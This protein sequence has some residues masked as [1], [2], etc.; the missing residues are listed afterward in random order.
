MPKTKYGNYYKYILFFILGLLICVPLFVR[1]DVL[2]IR[3]WDESRLAM[4]SIEMLHN[5]NYLVT[6]YDG[7]PDMWNTK[8]P[9]L[10]WIQVAFMKSMG[11]NELAVRIPSA[12]AGLL[13]CFML[14]YFSNRL[15][16]SYL[17]GFVAAF[18]LVCSPGFVDIHAT[19]TGDY[20]A[21]LTLFTTCSGLFFFLFCEKKQRKD[22]YFF[23]IST[24]LA[25]MTKSVAGLLFIPAIVLYSA[26]N[27]Q[28]IPLLKNKH[29]YYGFLIFIV[30]VLFYYLMREWQNHGYIAAVIKN[31]LGARYFKVLEKHN[32]G[33]LYYFKNLLNYRF[34]YWVLFLLSGLVLGFIHKNFE[35]RRIT[36]FS[37]LMASM[38]FV[39]ITLGKTKLEWYD[40][41]MYPFLSI[42]VA[43]F[44]HYIFIALKNYSWRPLPQLKMIVPYIAVI[45]V[46]IVPYQRVLATSFHPAE[47]AEDKT[48][49]DL[50][51]YLRDALTNNNSLQ[52]EYIVYAG[53]NAN[54][55]FYNR[56]LQNKGVKIDLKDRNKLEHGD[57]IIVSQNYMKRFI[58]KNYSFDTLETEG[59]IE[60]YRILK[61]K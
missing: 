39:V 57:I 46:F 42:P 10:L 40:V 47:K 35:I 19:R 34:N 41:P 17:F 18:V 45:L 25:I 48:F 53:Y 23:F 54:I 26:L 61:K 56:M 20:D 3:L 36:L 5:R 28:L 14:L 24:T 2:P 29:F 27:K 59:T 11:V 31:E 60:T 30:T 55:R 21:L 50:E 32:Y 58:E 9:L 51:Y 22:L 8:P 49:Y 7:K 38:Y 6:F 1:L 37:F 15:F 44:I 12:I 33:Y 43:V 16:K 52:G 13:T 4:N